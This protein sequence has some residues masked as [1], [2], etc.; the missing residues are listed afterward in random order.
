MN[1]STGD[2]T[3]DPTAVIRS[4]VLRAATGRQGEALGELLDLTGSND[5]PTAWLAAAAA[6][7]GMYWEG[8]TAQA[9]DMVQRIVERFGAVVGRFDLPLSVE[10][11]LAVAAGTL[12]D[13]TDGVP[14]LLEMAGHLPQPNALRNQLLWAAGHMAQHGPAAL[15][16][17]C[18]GEPEELWPLE[19]GL[20][21]RDPAGLDAGQV[22][23]V[24]QHATAKS[25]PDV[26]VHLHDAGL[27]LPE[28][29]LVWNALAESLLRAGRPAE[30]EQ[31]LLGARAVWYPLAVWDTLPIT[32]VLHPVL[33]QLITARVRDAYFTLPVGEAV[34][35]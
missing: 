18:L 20:L 10:F 23:R 12:Y 27:A 16:P 2:S 35:R 3:D 6:L 9:S 32:P 25:R 14:R 13:G 19:A 4:I 34:P 11:D 7:P 8:A 24:W 5:P 21:Q 26:L 29:V 31:I 22:R 30:A 28:D 17:L 1:S 15:M 33:R